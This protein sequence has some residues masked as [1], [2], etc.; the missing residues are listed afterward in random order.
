MVAG[1]GE[2]PCEVISYESDGLAR[3]LSRRPARSRVGRSSPRTLYVL[4]PNGASFTA[5]RKSFIQGDNE[6]HPSG[7]AI[8]PDGSLYVTDWGS[9]SYELHGKG[10]IWRVRWKDAK[11][12]KRPVDPKEAL[13]ELRPKDARGSGAG[14]GEN[15]SWPKD[16]AEAT[17]GEPI[18]APP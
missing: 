17:S 9:K 14:I 6:F 8:A 18:F 13:L 5:E 3:G 4:K 2:S 7:L 10:A 15:R 12:P 1:T 16:S 11:P